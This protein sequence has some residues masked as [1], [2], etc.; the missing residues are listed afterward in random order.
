MIQKKE[1]NAWAVEYESSLLLNHGDTISSEITLGVLIRRY[2]AEETIHKKSARVESLILNRFL[3][4]F[5][6][7]VNKPVNEVSPLDIANWKE[8]R[9]KLVKGST[10][11]RE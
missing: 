10:V 5:P 1:A 8:A 4:D 6:H 7:T 3:R 9:E 2:L 11:R